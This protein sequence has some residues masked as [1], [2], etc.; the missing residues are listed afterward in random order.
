M[1]LIINHLKNL[2]DYIDGTPNEDS[3][4]DE[5]SG[6]YEVPILYVTVWLDDQGNI[7]KDAVEDN[8]TPAS[9]RVPVKFLGTNI[10]EHQFLMV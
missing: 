7:I 3:D 5:D 1:R 9:E 2:N 10:L 6:T 8:K 4:E